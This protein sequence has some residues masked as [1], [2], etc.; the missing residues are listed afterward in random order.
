MHILGKNSMK[1]CKFVFEEM[2]F[3]LQNICLLKLSHCLNVINNIILRTIQCV[4]VN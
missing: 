2:M 4:C 1:Q 3:L